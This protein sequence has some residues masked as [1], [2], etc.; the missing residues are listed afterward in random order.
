MTCSDLII[1]LVDVKATYC[2]SIS[3]EIKRNRQ[4]EV[5]VECFLRCVAGF[6][7]SAEFLRTAAAT[8]LTVWET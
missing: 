8:D 2:T 7:H 1:S 4:Q 3:T 5:P 6:L